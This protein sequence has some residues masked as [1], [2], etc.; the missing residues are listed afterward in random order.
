MEKSANPWMMVGLI[1]C[2][3]FGHFFVVANEI[4][5]FK[6]FPYWFFLPHYTKLSYSF[7]AIPV[8]TI[9]VAL[10]ISRSAAHSAI[11]LLVIF[12][13]GVSLQYSFAMAKGGINTINDRMIS[14]G[15]S[16]FVH[17]AVKVQHTTEFIRDYEKSV[18][19]NKVGFF[20]ASKPPGTSLIYV[21][22]DR[23]ANG[24]ALDD[25]ERNPENFNKREARL[26]DLA[27]ATWPFL[28]YLP[29]FFIY[30]IGLR[31]SGRA[32]ALLAAMTYAVLPSVSLI[33]LHTDQAVYPLVA[34]AAVYFLLKSQQDSDF[35]AAG[36]LGIICYLA[37]FLSFGLLILF[38]FMASYSLLNVKRLSDLKVAGLSVLSFLIVAI[39]M[40]TKFGY[41]PIT[42]YALA[43][44]HH[45][46]AKGWDGQLAT[47]IYAAITNCVEYGLWIGVP[48]TLIFLFSFIQTLLD[49]KLRWSTYW[50]F[51]ASVVIAFIAVVLFG[52]T[53]AETGRLWMFMTPLVCVA[54]AGYLITAENLR[55]K[56]GMP[57][58]IFFIYSEFLAAVL[59]LQYQDFV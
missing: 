42:R 25:Q 58:S 31:V 26:R 3:L 34:S 24:S 41:D 59:I 22:F 2:L 36:L 10:L 17:T 13:T 52:Q 29:I 32:S 23:L 19:E 20:G 50:K 15:H 43:T 33:V 7:L 45:H 21:L 44:A 54:V 48:L 51:L 37:T 4:D 27:T 18:V 47:T 1:S 40:Y 11:K 16:E 8:I 14:S 30:L 35:L 6:Y 12:L 55:T 49:K 53:K 38:V 28:S 57:L 56:R 5:I 39:F 46:A 9:A